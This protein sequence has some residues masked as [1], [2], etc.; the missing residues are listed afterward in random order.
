MVLYTE[1]EHIIPL[2]RFLKMY[3]HA[4][5]MACHD[6]TAVDWIGTEKRFEMVYVLG[7]IMFWN[8]LQIHFRC[9]EVAHIES[10]SRIHPVADWLE[11]EV[12]DLYIRNHRDLR[13]NFA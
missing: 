5:F 9:H 11:R 1:P 2:M 7:N 13:R 4:R 12:Y 3:T 6:I 10:I 8:H